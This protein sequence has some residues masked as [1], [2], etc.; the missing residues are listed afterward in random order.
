[1]NELLV[2]AVAAQVVAVAFCIYVASRRG[3]TVHKRERERR[4]ERI[5]SAHL[6]HSASPVPPP[7]A[8]LPRAQP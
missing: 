4:D 8:R 3:R 6:A 2:I 7:D 5:A 1:L